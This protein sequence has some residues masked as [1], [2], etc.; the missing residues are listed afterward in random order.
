MYYF[1]ITPLGNEY[2]ENGY[3]NCGVDSHNEISLIDNNK[4]I[5]RNKLLIHTHNLKSIVLS[6]RSQT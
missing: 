3:I 4:A 1:F 6:K 5:Q 2:N